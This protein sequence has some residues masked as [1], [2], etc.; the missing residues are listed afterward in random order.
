MA[1]LSSLPA[2][3]NLSIDSVGGFLGELFSDLEIRIVRFVG[4]LYLTQ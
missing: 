1:I 2:I 4:S 3:V